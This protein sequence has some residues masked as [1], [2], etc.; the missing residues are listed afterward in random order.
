MNEHTRTA[1]YAIERGVTWPSMPMMLALFFFVA[2]FRESEEE[3]FFF[4]VAPFSSSSMKDSDDEGDI[5]IL[6]YVWAGTL[7]REELGDS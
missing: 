1:A 7:V 2:F 6:E 4:R 5:K 3:C